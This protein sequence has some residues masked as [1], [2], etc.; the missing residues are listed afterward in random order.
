MTRDEEFKYWMS[1]SDKAWSH[2][3]DLLEIS[4]KYSE[5]ADKLRVLESQE[6]E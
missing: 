3:Q 5:F 2:A 4:D 1:M 6:V